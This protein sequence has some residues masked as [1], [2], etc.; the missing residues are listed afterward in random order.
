MGIMTAAMDKAPSRTQH[1]IALPWA[2]LAI[3]I[4]AS[5]LLFAVVRE[6]V[7]NVAQLRFERQAS[8]AHSV[9]ES[10]LH[11]YADVLYALKALFASQDHVTRLRFHRF[12]ESLDI[13]HRYPG[14]DAVNFAA[15]V[16]AKDK[17][18][19]EEEVRADASLDPGG[20]PRFT[21]FPP[22]ERSE[23][24]V[25]VYLEPL[26][27][28]EFA[29]G[30]DLGANPGIVDPQILAATMRSGRDSGKLTASGLPIRI[31]TPDKEYTGLAMRLAVY[32]SDMPSDT[33][34]QRRAAYLG[35]VGAGFNVDNLM[36]GVLDDEILRYI[37]FTVHDAGP[38][39]DRSD[40]SSIRGK[41]LLFDSAKLINS[42]AV[43]V[44][45]DSASPEFTHV[46]PIEIAGRIWEIQ[47]TARKDAIMS[48]LDTVWPSWVLAGGVLSSLLLFGM[49]YSA[50]LSRNRALTLAAQMTKDLRET[51][52]RFRLITESASDLIVLIDPQGRRIYA[53]PAY[54]RLF[55][56]KTDLLGSDAFHEIHPEDK[57]R[58][59][60]AFSDTV[61]DGQN[62]DVEFRFLLPGGEVRWIESHRSAVFDSQGRVAHIVAVARDVTERR[63]QDEALRARDVQLQEAQVLANL[64]SWE[65]DVRTNSRRW[66]D[67]LAKIFGLRHD[68]VPPA[69]DGFYPL[70][71]PED[72][73][74][75]AKIA[76]EALRSGTDYENQFRIVRPDGV[77]RTVHNQA[78]VDRDESGRAVRIIGVCQDI[79]E[80][81]LAEE[82]VRASQERFRM[83]VE[84]VRDYAIYILDMNGYV[85]SWNL[86]AERIEGY[87]A[88]EIIG[89]HYSCFFLADHAARGD[90]GMQLQFASIQGRYESEGWRVRKNGS[91]FWAHIIVTPLLDETG[92]SRGFSEITHDVTER[93]RAEEDLHSYA[94]RLKTTSRR[95][96][97]VQEAERRLLARELHDR[98]GQNLTAL[99]I[100]LSI[101]AGGLPASAKPELAARLEEC[102]LLV[103]GTV[104]AMRN[105][106]AELRP[107]ALDDYGLPA[108]LRSLA[109]G[110]SHR[111]GIQV[112]F[113][114]D[115]R[116]TDL[117]K[118]VD[119]A[120]FRIAQE[121]LNNVAK[122]SNAHHV[123]IAIRRT[124]GR[125][126]LSV[127]D[128]GIGFDP[129]RIERSKREAGWG[130]LIMR[131]RA[132]AVGARFS[133]NAGLNTGVQVLVEYHVKG[134]GL[135]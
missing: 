79:T 84:N 7:E 2:A 63:R 87:R 103:A 134:G 21:I 23:Y 50:S 45:S 104:D 107:H 88:E 41:R 34:E 102:G 20:Y 43:Q 3:G 116:G 29:F 4:L 46:L 115:A 5:I 44:A 40:S 100:N 70:V 77:V 75:T 65:W 19:F 108:A 80:R 126:T 93:K 6:A 59:E 8:D 30:R 16:P 25:L 54:G 91:Q 135:T 101:V 13:K 109:T 39:P 68:Q 10:R 85:T 12:V 120:M 53:N 86:G 52:E 11:F 112:A 42:S 78:R 124:N 35:S 122:H 17:K 82:Q 18:R 36:K 106:M 26:V 97:E 90:P 129:K 133:L 38:T 1:W 51:E 57:E 48:R 118:P 66:S 33:V 127:R 58:V 56:D 123:E 71:H 95:L 67:Q 31:K 76:N 32:K 62:R 15:Y 119:L 98:V 105:V 69:F 74:R 111:T 128:N 92:K 83:M 89:K 114:G 73:E 130:L 132:E 64:G 27:G 24:Y 117:P 55:G 37:R 99:G 110:F 49:L 72:R 28:Y 22:G 81:K 61:R 125:A 94:D 9:I 14:F 131:E 60:K 96:V 113:E 121:A 47:Y